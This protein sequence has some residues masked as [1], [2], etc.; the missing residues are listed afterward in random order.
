[1]EL[2][3]LQAELTAEDM[4]KVSALDWVIYYPSQRA[5]AVW[6]A[7][8]IICY[9]LAVNKLEAARKAFSKVRTAT[10]NLSEI[11]YFSELW[12][13]PSDMYLSL[14]QGAGG[15]KWNLFLTNHELN[16]P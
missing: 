10:S 13:G 8:A 15:V 12:L 14:F 7:N 4:M 11:W 9:F 16:D 5:E 1:M 2:P 6:Q 3:D